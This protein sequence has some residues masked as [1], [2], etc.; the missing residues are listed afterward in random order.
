MFDTEKIIDT[1]LL[2]VGTASGLSNIENILGIIIL[3]VQILWLSVKI[4][5]KIINAIKGK[6]DLT[7]LD[8]DVSSVVSQIEELKDN[9]NLKDETVNNDKHGDE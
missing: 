4:T 8:D 6:K 5:F 3:I 9:L 7:T 2:T 1:C